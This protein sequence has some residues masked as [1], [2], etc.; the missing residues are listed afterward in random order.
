MG[1]TCSVSCYY[2]ECVLMRFSIY[3]VF[4]QNNSFL[5][6]TALLKIYACHNLQ[7][8]SDSCNLHKNNKWG[9]KIRKGVFTE[10]DDKKGTFETAYRIYLYTLRG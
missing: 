4:P 6:Y 8:K 3:V 9:T 7:V 10:K 5:I 1:P 2:Y